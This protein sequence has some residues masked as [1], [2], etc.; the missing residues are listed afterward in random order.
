MF[1]P[2]RRERLISRVNAELFG[3]SKT[4]TISLDYDFVSI[5]SP[6]ILRSYLEFMVLRG[7]FISSPSLY[8]GGISTYVESPP[9][10]SYGL[11]SRSTNQNY[12]LFTLNGCVVN[13]ARQ[14]CWADGGGI[15]WKKSSSSIR[16]QDTRTRA[17]NINRNSFLSPAFQP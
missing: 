16:Y 14:L 7:C 8:F 10:T 1:A 3:L 5:C 15:L 9:I 13:V 2:W 4:F 12:P 11:S 17:I 6:N